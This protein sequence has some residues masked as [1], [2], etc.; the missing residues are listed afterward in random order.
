VIQ[1]YSMEQLVRLGVSWVWMGV[2]GKN[3]PYVKL[4]GIDTR[5]LIRRLQAHGIRVLASSIIGLENHTPHNI[6]RVIDDAVRHQ[7]DFHQFMLYMPLP[8]T[9]LYEEISTDGRLLDETACPQADTHGQYRFNY[10]HA[11]IP[12][13]MESELIV[14]AFQRDFSVNGPSMARVVRTTL[15]G[16]RRYKNHPSGRIRRRFAR[17]AR[18]LATVYSAVAAAVK[19]YYRRDPTLRDETAGLLA[20]LNREFGWVSRMAAAF[21]GPYLLWKIR[22]EE[23]RLARG[24]TYEPPTC[25][26]V[27]ENVPLEA[28][29]GA[30]RCR[31]VTSRLAAPPPDAPQPTRAPRLD[32]KE[33]RQLCE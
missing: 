14:R 16:W 30:S 21:G 17:E 8:G 22:Q 5:E 26:E 31:Y 25:C 6:D 10:R 9:P 12:P 24:W 13:G 7:A 28:Y 27:N 2:E 32:E 33:E 1:S 3:S 15:T 11:H 18:G 4:R 23:R 19:R 20:D 29:P